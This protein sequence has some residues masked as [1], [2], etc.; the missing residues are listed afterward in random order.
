MY[1]TDVSQ[2]WHLSGEY[3]MMHIESLLYEDEDTNLNID[4][5]IEQSWRLH[6][7]VHQ[8]ILRKKL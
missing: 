4:A 3:H 7:S 5:C 6:M 2:Q 8:W 1:Q